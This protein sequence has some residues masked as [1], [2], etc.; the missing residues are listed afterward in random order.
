M[1]QVTQENAA[2]SEELAAVMSM[3]KT[4][5]SKNGK[6]KRHDNRKLLPDGTGM[7][8]WDKQTGPVPKRFQHKQVIPLE[9]DG[10][11]DF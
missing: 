5:E 2:S 3:F 6:Q 9:E 8:T 4:D 10:F 7:S 1:Y 11:S